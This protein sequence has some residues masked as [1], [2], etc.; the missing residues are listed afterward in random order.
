MYPVSSLAESNE[1]KQIVQQ[2]NPSSC[3][4]S[5]KID[6]KNANVLKSH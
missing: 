1:T 6:W 5:V 4:N 3:N 2:N